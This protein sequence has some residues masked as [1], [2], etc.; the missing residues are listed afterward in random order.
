MMN[1]VSIYYVRIYS[2][3]RSPSR[4]ANR[5]LASQEIPRILWD[6]NA[7][8][9]INKCPTPVPFLSHVDPLHVLTSHFM[10]IDVNIILP[11]TSRSSKLSLSLRFPHQNP[12]YASSLFHTCYPAP[13]TSFFSICSPENYWLRST[14][15]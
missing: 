13:P 15:D 14:D 10:K 5:F 6:P 12:V 11:F 4:E 7:H 2:I 9:R 8:Y 3:E 1:K